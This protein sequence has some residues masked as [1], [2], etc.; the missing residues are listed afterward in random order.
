MS[1]LILS[2]FQFACW[3]RQAPHLL[4]APDN[5]K[6]KGELD[7]TAYTYRWQHPDPRMDALQQQVA[8]LVSKAEHCKADPIETFFHV[9]ALTLAAQGQIFPV[10]H[11]LQC[12]GPRQI[13]PHL[14]KSWFC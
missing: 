10:A 13:L 2:I 14:T 4:N 12:Y 3:S 11:A 1:I 9:K 5:N 8:H 7:S 6:W